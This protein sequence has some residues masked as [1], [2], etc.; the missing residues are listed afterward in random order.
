MVKMCS[1]KLSRDASAARTSRARPKSSLLMM[2]DY[3]ELSPASLTMVTLL[4]MPKRSA[5]LSES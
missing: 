1:K 3:F 4:F 2:S 5:V